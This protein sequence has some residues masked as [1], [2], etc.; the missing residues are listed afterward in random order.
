MFGFFNV[1]VGMMFC[2]DM[3][4]VEG[5]IEN[6]FDKEYIIDG[7]NIGGGFGILIFILGVLCFIGGGVLVW[8]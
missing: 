8:F 1:C 2:E 6:F 4:C 5:Y 3:F 7:G